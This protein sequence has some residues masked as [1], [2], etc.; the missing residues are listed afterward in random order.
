MIHARDL[1]RLKNAY[2]NFYG[3]IFMVLQS[4]AKLINSPQKIR[5]IQNYSEVNIREVKKHI[6][7]P[8]GRKLE[9]NL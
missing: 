4:T 9:L 5:A 1:S 8:G 2:I 7:I 6:R 3:M